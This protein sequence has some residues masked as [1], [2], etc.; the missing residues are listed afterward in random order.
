MS[1]SFPQMLEERRRRRD[2]ERMRLQKRIAELSREGE[3][4]AIAARVYQDA[5]TSQTATA[6]AIASDPATPKPDAVEASPYKV[7]M[8]P[9]ASVE[10]PK[11]KD[12]ILAVLRDAY[13]NGL[14]A[15]NI[16]GKVYLRFKEQI[17]SN[18]TTVTLGRFSKDGIV[19]NDSRV[20]F[21]V[22]A[23]PAPNIPQ[24][25]GTAHKLAPE[26][27]LLEALE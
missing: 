20:W 19:K 11:V 7:V 2:A 8:M 25:N 18:T 24:L 4:D 1:E 17:N 9:R 3:D 15:A 21:Y 10:A 27:S 13:P 16:K 14:T 12:M 26:S 6:V 23:A 5:M 22:P